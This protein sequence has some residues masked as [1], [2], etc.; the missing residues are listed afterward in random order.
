MSFYGLT[1]HE[2][3]K[4]PIRTFWMLDRNIDRLNAE[5]DYRMV[6]AVRVANTDGEVFAEQMQVLRDRVGKT[7]EVDEAKRALTME[8]DAEGVQRLKNL[9]KAYG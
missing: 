7:I 3:L 6:M 2:T 8:Y 4:L 9:G 5:S 1:Y